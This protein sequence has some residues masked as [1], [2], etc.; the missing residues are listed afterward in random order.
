MAVLENPTLNGK[1]ENEFLER[2]IN[3]LLVLGVPAEVAKESV[4][5][6][7][8]DTGLAARVVG[9]TKGTMDVWRC[10]AQRKGKRKLPG[11]A[12]RTIP[13]IRIGSKVKYRLEDL[14]QCLESRRQTEPAE[15]TKSRRKPSLKPRRGS[16]PR[17]AR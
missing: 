16:A 11:S 15:P 10:H 17:S 1:S 9:L 13:F 8:L 12:A 6:G 7:L 2:V 14:I 3:R 5:V 4:A